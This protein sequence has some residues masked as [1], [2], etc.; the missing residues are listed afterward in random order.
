MLPPR[1]AR[2]ISARANGACVRR[3]ALAPP[4]PPPHFGEVA[5]ADDERVAGR[6]LVPGAQHY[7]HA[8]VFGPAQRL[9]FLHGNERAPVNPH[10]PVGEL[11]RSEE[12]TSELPSRM[13]LSY[14]VFC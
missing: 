10:E 1:V 2:P 14:A 9:A 8:A 6:A 13:R 5:A 11:L 12:H 3:G 7:L 4:Q